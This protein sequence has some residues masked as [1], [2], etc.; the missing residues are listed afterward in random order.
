MR[1]SALSVLAKTRVKLRA[2]RQASR[3]AS[4]YFVPGVTATGAI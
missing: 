1:M 3:L 4:D 2:R